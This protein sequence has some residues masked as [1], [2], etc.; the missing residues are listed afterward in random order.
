[1]V[2]NI[3]R[4]FCIANDVLAER[5]TEVQRSQHINQSD[6]R[7]Y[8]QSYVTNTS[9]VDGRRRFAD[10]EPQHDH[11]E[12]FQGFS[13]SREKGLP[14]KLPARQKAEIDGEKSLLD[15]Q[16]RIQLLRSESASDSDVENAISEA[17]NYKARI[18][19]KRLVLYQL[20]WVQQRRDWKIATRGR[21]VPNDGWRNDLENVLSGIMPERARL[22]AAMLSELST[23][24]QERKQ[25][26]ADL[27]SLISRDSTAFSLPGERLADGKCPVADCEALV[28][29]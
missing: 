2:S 27:C 21:E 26:I 6:P 5:Y 18:T 15:L 22:A 19:R 9:S 13:Q 4:S 20:E 24:E 17:R 12:Y 11:V 29:R 10:E 25:C 14:T 28:S 8:G 1:M 7:V 23:T 3:G 16:K